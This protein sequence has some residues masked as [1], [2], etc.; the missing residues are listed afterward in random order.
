MNITKKLLF[1]YY[2]LFLSPGQ[3][4]AQ[5][6][7]D[8]EF[9]GR[10]QADATYYNN[11]VFKYQDGSEVRRARL[12]IR[13]DLT[14]NW[15]YKFQYDFAPD[16]PESRDVYIRY[17]GLDNT[18]I[19]LGNFKVFGGLEELTSS[20][21]MTFTE[22]GLPNA[23]VKG[24]RVGVGYQNWNE[25]YS[26]A[27]SAYGHEANNLARGRGVSGRF[28]YR[29]NLGE[30]KI[31]HLGLHIARDDDDDG[32]TRLRTR[33]ETHQDSHR[34]I[35]TGTLIDIDQRNTLGFEVSY[36]NGRFSAQSEVTN[37]K[38][39]R[40]F[41][42]DFNA[43]GGYVY[44]SYFLTDDSRPYSNIDAAFA[45]LRPSADSA[46]A[47]AWEIAARFSTLD[48]NDGLIRGGKVDSMTL[49]LNYYMTSDLRF[50]ANYVMA[51]GET[52]SGTDEPGA[53]QLR[54][55]YTF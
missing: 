37:Q 1:F 47:G 32:T 3:T 31:L 8:I 46:G 18:R 9:G 36:V 30:G 29:P 19:T 33:P 17:N 26:I 35:D 42:S 20:N 27:I 6:A 40:K 11:D 43:E 12:F 41:A 2:L 50:T 14:E 39:K 25:R 53:V 48:L 10:I 38:V 52:V 7:P 34:I 45:T 24:R 22:R 54:L 13:G 21:N 28:A 49:G 51:E 4:Y 16:Q 15:D 55:R 23:L 5:D 44:V